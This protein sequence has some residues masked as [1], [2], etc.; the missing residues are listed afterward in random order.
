VVKLIKKK[1]NASSWHF[2]RNRRLFFKNVRSHAN[3]PVI[4]TTFR[5]VVTIVLQ[6]IYDCKR[7]IY[8]MVT[9]IGGS[10]V[11]IGSLYSYIVLRTIFTTRK[12]FVSIS[13]KRRTELEQN[14][15]M[16][17]RSREHVEQRSYYV[18]SRNA[19]RG[20]L[21]FWVHG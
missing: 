1:K 6:E 17:N 19:T 2:L 11:V 9:N 18:R 12:G 20:D 21:I 15:E 5:R 14:L 3:L 7:H 8:D 4:S 13:R 10:E 16:L